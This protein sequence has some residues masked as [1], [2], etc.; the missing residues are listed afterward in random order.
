MAVTYMQ[1]GI[2]HKAGTSK[3]RLSLPKK[4]M[5]YMSVRYGIC[6][7]YLYLE[8]QIFRNT[9]VIKQIKLY[10]PENGRCRMIIIYEV[11][12]VEPLPD[13]G[14][15]L[16]IDLGLHNLM[17][18]YNSETAETFIAG[19][20]YLAL[21]HYYSK[22]I[23]RVQSQWYSI[24]SKNGVKHPKTSRHIQ[25]L[26]K[27]KNHAIRDY[28]HKVT[29]YIASYCEKN[30]IHTVI[31]GDLTG[32]R[33]DKDYGHV[34]NQ[35]FHALPYQKLGILLIYKLA[36]CGIRVVFKKEA[37]SS[38]CSPLAEA[39]SRNTAVKENRVY[40]GLYRDGGYTWNADTVGAYNILRLY[41]HSEKIEMQF[42]PLEMKTPYV[43]KVAV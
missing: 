26:Y 19:R 15:Y 36:L 20:K 3:V 37:Y 24:Q 10:P 12:D 13:N 21:C 39:V 2:V 41:C 32:I 38:Q 40:R 18:C 9:D 8:N 35:K 17:T 42:H 34:I 22:E 27:K 5:E 7:T 14:K 30:D 31:V 23:A 11:P 25:L 28:L 1:K 33:K 29:R 4:L 43:A 6:D 16:S